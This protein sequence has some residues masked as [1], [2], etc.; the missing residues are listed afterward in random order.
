MIDLID[1][2]TTQGI[3][4]TYTTN[5]DMDVF[6]YQMGDFPILEKTSIDL[7]IVSP[8]KNTVVV[9]GEMSLTLSIPCDRCLKEMKH[10]M[11]VTV[12]RTFLI[13]EADEESEEEFLPEPVLDVEELLFTEILINFPAKVLCKDDCKGV[14]KVCGKNLNEGECGCDR[15]VLDPRMAAVKS[16]AKRS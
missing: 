15:T 11:D 16:E 13:G 5:L 14:C 3:A 8:K 6:S 7:K 1:V 2:L 4:K 9:S 10:R 12:D